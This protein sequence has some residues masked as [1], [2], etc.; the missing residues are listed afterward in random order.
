MVV[1]QKHHDHRTAD[2]SGERPMFGEDSCVTVS[3]DP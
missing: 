1:L 3:F 2:G